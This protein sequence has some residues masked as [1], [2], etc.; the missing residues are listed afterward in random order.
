MLV[1]DEGLQ[2]FVVY[3]SWLFMQMEA[4]GSLKGIKSLVQTQIF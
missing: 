1:S 2:G 3:R 4:V